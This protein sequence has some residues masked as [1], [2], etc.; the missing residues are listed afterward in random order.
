[1]RQDALSIPLAKARGLPRFFGNGTILVKQNKTEGIKRGVSPYV[2]EIG[3]LANDRP[4]NQFPPQKAKSI[5]MDSEICSIIEPAKAG[6]ANLGDNLL[7]GVPLSGVPFLLIALLFSLFP[8]LLLAAPKKAAPPPDFLPPPVTAPRQ[9][10]Q[11]EYV[12][13][14][15]NHHSWHINDAHALIW[16][17]RPFLPAGGVFQSRYLSIDQT[18][19]NWQA[20]VADLSLLKK[21]GVT[22]IILM[23]TA[24]GIGGLTLIPPVAMQRVL[25]YLDENGFQYGLNIDAFPRDPLV[26]TIVDPAISRIPAPVAGGVTTFRNLSG[27]VSATYLLVNAADGSNLASGAATVVD[28]QTVTIPLAQNQGG[29]GTVLLLYPQRLLL[30]DSLEGRHLPDIWSNQDEYRDGLLLY[31]SKIHFGAGL[32]FFVDPLVDEPGFFGDAGGGMVPVGDTYRF[33]FQT[34]LQNRYDR[35]IAHLN[36]VWALKD[37]D[38]TSFAAAARCL[39]LWFQA[40][41]V[42]ALTDPATRKFY[43]VYTSHSAFWDDVRAFRTESLR[44]SMNEI[45]SALKGGVADVPVVY[46]WTQP[47][48]LFVNGAQAGYDGLMAVS[49]EHDQDLVKDAVGW[50]LSSVEQSPR[51]Q[52][53]I[54]Q[55]Q[56][57]PS[58]KTVGYASRGQ[59]TADRLA[60]QSIGVKGYFINALRRLPPGKWAATSLLE[61]PEQLDWLHSD[62][63]NLSLDAPS[64][65]E[66]RPTIVF[67]PLNVGLTDAGIQQFPNGAWWLPTYEEGEGLDLGRGLSGYVLTQPGGK[68]TITIWSPDGTVHEARFELARP[69][70]IYVSSLTGDPVS[71]SE[72]KAVLTIPVSVTPVLVT[73]IG[74]LPIPVGAVEAEEA[75]AK[76]LVELGQKNNVPMAV[77]EQRLYYIHNSVLIRKTV[78]SDSTAYGLFRVL[79]AQLTAALSPYVWIEGEQAA[80]QSFNSIVSSSDSSGGAY[81]WLDSD[82]PVPAGQDGYHADYSF[83]ISTPGDYDVWAA[84]APGPPATGGASPITYSVN[85]GTPFDVVQP[86]TAGAGYGSLI[87]SGTSTRDGQFLWCKVGSAH[88]NSG[89][90]SLSLVVIGQ[91]PATGRYTLGI[92]CLCITRGRF[93]PNGP[94]RP[95]VE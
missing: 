64:L 82:H 74:A 18:E 87:S 44:R 36:E 31:F 80:R 84:L 48:P 46:R 38:I 66:T 77:F 24:P 42:G 94:Q 3:G 13:A 75:E 22:T 21:H 37:D 1:M 61:A 51:S 59:M 27:V 71:A 25:R 90:H 62:A 9:I 28:A 47:N 26:A 33:Q 50:A 20:D 58:G 39:P 79:N 17:G 16:G 4:G 45:A 70:T 41:G 10:T 12:D 57:T 56:P 60:L 15:G 7:S 95:P 86:L 92:D 69:A 34:W 53:L 19:A 49:D 93:L 40:K 43:A 52:W 88:L 76:R 55:I 5:F 68:R 2:S 72:K 6:F 14:Q 73:G 23:P 81:L 32:R 83:S 35:N 54:A 85:G 30:P 78:T 89:D 63:V 91:A 65:S 11:G 8:S 67:Y 29:E